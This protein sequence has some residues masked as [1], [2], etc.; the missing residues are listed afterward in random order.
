M[1]TASA[2]STSSSE[3]HESDKSARSHVIVDLG[4]PQASAQ[5]RRLRKGTGKLF[6]HVESIIDDLVAAGTVKASAQPVVI[7]VR[8]LPSLWP[9]GGHDD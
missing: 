1:A 4:E 8:E 7:I 3:H 2:A 5:I 6:H 9:F